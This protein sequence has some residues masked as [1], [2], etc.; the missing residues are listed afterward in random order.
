MHCKICLKRSQYFSICVHPYCEEC[1]T[2]NF[3]KCSKCEFGKLPELQTTN[4]THTTEPVQTEPVQTP[5]VTEEKDVGIIYN[6]FN[7]VLNQLNL[8]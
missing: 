7:Y 8:C 3:S 4:T 6:I 1:Y 5:Q 2:I